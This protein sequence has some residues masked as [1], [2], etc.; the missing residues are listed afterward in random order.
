M[1]GNASI[2]RA[3]KSDSLPDA[4]SLARAWQLTTLLTVAIAVQCLSAPAAPATQRM[5]VAPYPLPRM[6][7]NPLTPPLPDVGEFCPLEDGTPP[8]KFAGFRHFDDTK[9]DVGIG[10]DSYSDN[11]N[12]KDDEKESGVEHYIQELFLGIIVYP[13]ETGKIQ[14]TSGYFRGT[15]GSQDTLVPS[16][17][18]YGVSEQFEL[19]LDVPFRHLRDG[20]QSEQGVEAIEVGAY[21]NFYNDGE[22]GQS[23]GVGFNLGSP[24]G[25]PDFGP[26]S[27]HYEPFFVAYRDFKPWAVNFS[28]LL[29]VENPLT[30][31]EP[32]QTS[33]ELALAALRPMGKFVS[34]LEFSADL[35]RDETP[36]RLAPELYWHPTGKDSFEVAISAPI[37]LNRDTPDI[38]LFL[39]MTIEFGGEEEEKKSQ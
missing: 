30:P 32:T 20:S 34:V 26:R 31:G 17:L 39:Q 21:Y 38:G 33:G 7:E 5:D 22:S 10:K 1:R 23:Y 14:I 6:Q 24:T 2:S 25:A 36:L 13:P 37:G 29:D 11:E 3:E 15:P 8:L 19:S 18:V 35:E 4:L 16:A 28:A 12:D 27:F 9:S